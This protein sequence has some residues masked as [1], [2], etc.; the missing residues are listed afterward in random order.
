M[1]V[2]GLGVGYQ[3]SVEEYIIGPA[4]ALSDD[5]ETIKED[6]IRLYGP[7]G[8]VSW[9]AKPV[10]DQSLLAA[11][12]SQ[13]SPPSPGLSLVD[14]LVTLF[15]SIHDKPL[16]ETGSLTLFSNMGSML[17]TE[18][19]NGKQEDYRIFESLKDD[20][21]DLT[22]SVVTD[23][24]NEELHKPFLSR[25]ATGTGTPSQLPA[26]TM[27][28]CHSSMMQGNDD[29]PSSSM[30]DIGGGWQLA[31]K[32]S[33][34]IGGPQRI[35]LHQ[36]GSPASRRG[37]IV[38]NHAADQI[39]E[40]GDKFIHAT[41]LVSQPQVHPL[42]LVAKR[43]SWRDLSEPGVKRALFVGVGM[44]ILQQVKFC[45][46]SFHSYYSSPFCLV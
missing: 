19:Q 14:P 35:Y 33:N 43:P 46:I 25:E 13:G 31:W 15:G 12:S 11:V 37:S 29:E 45:L 42:Q 17:S 41:A 28:R 7:E 6:E 36:E 9:V 2:E 39:S 22:V 21:Q 30:T 32:W 10:K 20:D 44:Y 5:H 16:S 23:S 27:F 4:N 8:E 26:D 1:L 38:S 34:K 40:E 24:D 3:T 18:P